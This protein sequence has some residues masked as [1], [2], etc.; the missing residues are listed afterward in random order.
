MD[1]PRCAEEQCTSEQPVHV[2]RGGDFCTSVRHVSVAAPGGGRDILHDCSLTLQPGEIVALVGAT[3]TGKSLLASLLPRLND[4]T[5][6]RLLLG[7][8]AN[9]WQDI[10]DLQLGPLRQRVHVVP[11]ESFLFAGTLAANLRL[12]APAATEE[13]L[14]AALHLAA[15]EDVLQ[16]L[17]QGLE[18]PLGDRGVTLSG[19]QRQRLCLA[20]ALLGTPDILCLDDAT[21]ALDAISERQVLNNLRQL[22]GTTVLVISS[23][24]STILLADRVLVL[25][26][27]RIT[28]HGRHTDLQS[29]HAHYRDLLGI[30]HG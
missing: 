25:D 7:S 16:R 8:D 18:T 26:D 30:D 29:T 28:A 24:L 6:G 3:G 23:K 27:G 2:G 11:Q 19:G 21:S 12:T 5:A 1:P 15:A 10:R 9:G 17:P 20:R 14:R 13:Q 22:H 4:V